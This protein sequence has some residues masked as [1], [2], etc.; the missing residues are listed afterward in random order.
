MKSESDGSTSS[1]S[2]STS[3]YDLKDLLKVY[4]NSA[5]KDFKKK[6]SANKWFA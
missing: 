5:S 1:F 4:N 2:Y 6:Y 3:L